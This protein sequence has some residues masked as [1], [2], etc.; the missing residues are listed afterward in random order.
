[1]YIFMLN[2]IKKFNE[3]IFNITEIGPL[4]CIRKNRAFKSTLYENKV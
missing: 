3:N 4:F 2:L 1:M